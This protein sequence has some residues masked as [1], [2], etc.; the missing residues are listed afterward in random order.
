MAPFGIPV[1]AIAPNYLYSEAYFPKA[2]FIDHPIGRDFIREV[3][4][5]G[6]LGEPE[7]IGELIS[8]LANMKGSFYRV[9]DSGVNPFQSTLMVPSAIWSRQRKAGITASPGP[10]MIST[11]TGRSMKF[12]FRRRRINVGFYK[13][14]FP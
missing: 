9:L 4:P 7:E 1:N 14:F 12:F 13:R 10:F 6:R 2:K 5:A 3:V 11:K 8:Y